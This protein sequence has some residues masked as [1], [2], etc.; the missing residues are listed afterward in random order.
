MD[1]DALNGATA[2]GAVRDLLAC[3]ASEAWAEEMAAR[4]PFAAA[5]DLLTAASD[6]WWTLGE[7]DWLQAFAAHPRI[8]EQRD[9]DDRHSAWSRAEQAGTAAVSAATQ[10]SLVACN[11]EYEARFGH[12]Y[13]V[14]AGGKTAEELLDLCRARIA[15]DPD[16]EFLIAAAEQV[17]ITDLRLRK[18]IGID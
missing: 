18:L 16:E 14:F 17:R 12:V 15:N 5:D 1:L 9:G 2:E 3:C 8:G 7:E 11:R 6:V 10:D 4:R 13:L